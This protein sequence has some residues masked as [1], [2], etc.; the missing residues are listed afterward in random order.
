MAHN[1]KF[2]DKKY[3]Q[4]ASEELRKLMLLDHWRLASEDTSAMIKR[5]IRQGADPRILLEKL[6]IKHMID[7]YENLFEMLA[8]FGEYKFL[9]ELFDMGLEPTRRLITKA[10]TEEG[11][12]VKI[13]KTINVILDKNPELID[14]SDEYQ[15]GNTILMSAIILRFGRQFI[16]SLLKRGA[17]PDLQND[18][19]Q[20]ALMIAAADH[21]IDLIELLFRYGADDELQNKNGRTMMNYLNNNN[22]NYNGGKRSKRKTRR[23]KKKSHRRHKTRRH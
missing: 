2:N 9:K 6:P 10:M 18:F 20:T 17:N 19:G 7:A 3:N 14:V 8:F 11:D 15:S 5:A 13:K 4:D 16:E 23:G 12:I 1:K 21:D 22:N